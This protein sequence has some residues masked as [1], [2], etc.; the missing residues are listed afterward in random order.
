L[1]EIYKVTSQIDVQQNAWQS[2]KVGVL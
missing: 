2:F 1:V